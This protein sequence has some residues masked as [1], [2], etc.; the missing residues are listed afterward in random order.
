MFFE[1]TIQASDGVELYVQGRLTAR[2]KGGAV[3][4]HGFGEHGGRHGHVVDALSAEGLSC[5]LLDHRGHGRSGGVRGGVLRWDEYLDDLDLFMDF[6]SQKLG[7]RPEVLLGHSMGGL[8]AVS[9]LL[10]R[11]HDFKLLV[12]SAP[13]FKTAEP[14]PPAKALMVKLLS[15]LAPRLMLKNAVDPTTLSHDPAVG[16]AYVDDPLVL[17][18]GTARLFREIFA[19]QRRCL[20][21]AGQLEVDS[22]L[23]ML[24]SGDRLIDHRAGLAFY[25][26]LAVA[27][28]QLKLYDGLYHEIF[29]ELD[30]TLVMADLRQ[31]LAPR[32]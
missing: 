1:Q 5:L 27:D 20:E 30:K 7:R 28:K 31:W 32:L 10:N 11:R 29:N 6:A 22:A 26:R 23:V 16:R 14:L 25:E 3:I 12:L 13:F 21:N 24:G 19:E 18:G 17:P 4:L 8:M 9:Y 15:A 2:A